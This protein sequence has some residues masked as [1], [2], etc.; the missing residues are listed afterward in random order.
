MNLS[1]LVSVSLANCPYQETNQLPHS[2]QLSS[3]TRFKKC[4]EKHAYIKA[5]SY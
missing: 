1:K 4:F 3:E 2:I 5:R